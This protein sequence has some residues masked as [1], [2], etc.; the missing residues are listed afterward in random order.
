M[1]FISYK[2][3][4][5]CCFPKLQQLLACLVDMR[6]PLSSLGILLEYLN[7]DE[8]L[9]LFEQV[10]TFPH[11]FY[12]SSVIDTICYALKDSEL[13]AAYTSD[14]A[15]SRY[16]GCLSCAEIPSNF[17]K[18]S[19]KTLANIYRITDCCHGGLQGDSQASYRWAMCNIHVLLKFLYTSCYSVNIYMIYSIIKEVSFVVQ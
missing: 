10:T 5:T 11:T 13:F 14:M 19:S 12:V 9:L 2:E 1:C 3:T 4:N 17:Y 7:P 15:R 6:S 18:K 8:I 16:H